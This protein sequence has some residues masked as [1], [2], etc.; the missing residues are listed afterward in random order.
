MIR[1]P[2]ITA[3][4]S[5]PR[6]RLEPDAIGVMQDTV[7]G[8]ASSAPAATSG[9]TLAA[10]AAATAYGAGATLILTAIPILVI[11]NAYR[12]LNQW[13]ASCSA[14]FEWVGRAI[15]PYLGYMTGWLML[16]YY[17]IGGVALIVPLGP[18]VLQAF[19]TSTSSP[20]PNLAITSAVIVVM[21]VIAVVGIRPT[22]R[23]QIGM[24]VV[25]YAI[26]VGL[27]VAGFIF[28]A[29]HHPGTVHL[30]WAWLRPTGIGGRGS[31]T[32]AFLISA[33]VIAGWDGTMYVNEEVRHRRTN[34]GRAAMWAAGLLALLYTL[35]QVG[36]QGVVSPA[37]L[38]AHSAS[39]LVYTTQ[40]FAGSG[41]GKVMAAAVALSVIATTGVGIALTARIMF[42][43][44][45]WQALPAFLGHVSRRFA[46]P[47]AASVLT[48]VLLLGLIWVYILGTSLANV[49]GD[50]LSVSSW[51][52]I[53]F[54]ILTALAMT[55]FYRRHILIHPRN[56]LTVGVLPLASAAFLGWV[57]VRSFL[58]ATSAQ[59]WSMV[60]VIAVGVLL[61]LLAR[62]AWRSPFFRIV[63]ETDPGRR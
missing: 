11:A 17:V 36:L 62:F 38:R 30:S 14:S 52:T 59:K 15:N 31:L 37:K 32:G 42:G 8:M 9:L 16:A 34:P 54:Y 21:L 40:A 47:V 12:R 19:G 41:W 22:A 63:R 35:V 29:G 48:A 53:A 49:F 20:W 24:A 28:V 23:T 61:M 27:A 50:L 51:L 2:V 5:A 26:L 18:S 56:I 7:I 60:A 25:E 39:V 46:T 10:L 44:A 57:L 6:Q 4:G 58:L 13:N 3:A 1:E 55:V 43:M 33:F 45:S